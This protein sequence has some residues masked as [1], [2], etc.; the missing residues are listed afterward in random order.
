MGFLESFDTSGDT[1]C[2]L[3]SFVLPYVKE[4]ENEILTKLSGITLGGYIRIIDLDIAPNLKKMKFDLDNNIYSLFA[5]NT[6]FARFMCLLQINEANRGLFEKYINDAFESA[7]KINGKSDLLVKKL[8]RKNEDDS[9]N[10]NDDKQQP[11]CYMINFK[12]MELAFGPILSLH[13]KQH[14][15]SQDKLK[16]YEID[17]LNVTDESQK[18]FVGKWYKFPIKGSC[19]YADFQSV[20]TLSSTQAVDAV[21]AYAQTLIQS[22]VESTKPK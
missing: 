9:S 11:Q 19:V 6:L 13:I 22:Y 14:G 1:Y 16:K 4:L 21:K 2:Y 3:V 15:V 18:Y 7:C 5:E 10:D 20:V 12:Q 8:N 17:Y